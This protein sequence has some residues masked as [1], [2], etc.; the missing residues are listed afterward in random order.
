MAVDEVSLDYGR[1]A[2]GGV[3]NLS[4]REK[5]TFTIPFLTGKENRIIGFQNGLE[6]YTCQIN[7]N[8][9][10]TFIRT[11]TNVIKASRT[12]VVQVVE[13]E[14]VGKNTAGSILII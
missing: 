12:K 5:A 10:R 2:N 14:K 13:E 7:I 11:N 4:I 8:V 3:Q 9:V 1:T 6:A